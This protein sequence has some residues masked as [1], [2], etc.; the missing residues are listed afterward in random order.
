MRRMTKKDVTGKV[1]I[2]PG[3]TN[4]ANENGGYKKIGYNAGVNGW[5]WS[6]YKR[7]ND[8]VLYIQGYRNLPKKIKKRLTFI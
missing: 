5:N 3:T 8:P 4:T 7:D 1:I 2:L 6:A